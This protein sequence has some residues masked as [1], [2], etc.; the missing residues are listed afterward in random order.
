MLAATLDRKGN[1]ETTI[2]HDHREI[3]AEALA[4]ACNHPICLVLRFSFPMVRVRTCR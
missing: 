2:A 3:Q 4:E 1:L